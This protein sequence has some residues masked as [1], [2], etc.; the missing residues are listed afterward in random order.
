MENYDC[1]EKM[2]D[3]SSKFINS[4][5]ATGIR[6]PL[7][8]A[9]ALPYLS[10]RTCLAAGIS[11]PMDTVGGAVE[12]GKLSRLYSALE[13]GTPQEQDEIKNKFNDVR[14]SP[15]IMNG[16]FI[17]RRI[18]QLLVPKEDAKSR[19]VSL[20]PMTSI[21]LSVLLLGAVARHNHNFFSEKA[22]TTIR[23]RRAHLAFGGSNPHNLG[24]FAAKRLIQHPIFLSAPKAM[25][26]KAAIRQASGKGT[27][28][29]LS[30]LS[31]Q[32][33]NILT[34][35]AMINGAPL[36]AAWGM[37][38]ALE[39]EMHGPKVIGVCL[40]VHGIEPLGEHESAIFEPNQKRGSAFTFE[41]SRNGSDYVKSSIHLSLQPEASGH[42]RVSLIFELS[43]ALDSVP[44]TVEPFLKTGK[45]SG[46]MITSHEVPTMHDDYSTL[47]GCLPVGRVV[48]DRPD[49]MTV[50]SPLENFVNTLGYFHQE[51]W[52]SATNIGYTAI[53]NFGIRGGAREGY[54]HAFSEPLIGIIQYISTIDRKQGYFWRAAWKGESFLLQGDQKSE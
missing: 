16:D 39:R 19:Y 53:T 49:V 48:I 18:R 27:Y 43:E 5:T 36:F 47:L 52:L 3:F 30:D 9:L 21:G 4:N 42:M 46:G 41:K 37:G 44:S 40:V 31:V 24:Y 50:G 38:H 23:I 26:G 2:V 7:D 17:D 28:L 34:N 51:E 13:S 6:L 29:I 11:L 35:S 54:L 14:E 45:F 1:I 20:S 8:S 22:S 32:S 33:A 15:F 10:A 25:R 12:V